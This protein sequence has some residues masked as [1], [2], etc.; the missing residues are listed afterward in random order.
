MARNDILLDDVDGDLIIFNGDFLVSDSDQ[1][2]IQH[3]LTAQ[4]GQFYQ[5]PLLGLGI[6]NYNNAT[7]DPIDLEQSIK[8]QIKSDDYRPILIQVNENFDVFIDAEPITT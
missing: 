3:I 4:K 2:H 7:I 1:Q 8:I 6:L 5:W